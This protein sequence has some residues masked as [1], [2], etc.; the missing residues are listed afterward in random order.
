MN[1]IFWDKQPIGIN[2]YDCL[3]SEQIK[4][5]DINKTSRQP[6]NLPNSMS[7]FTIL[8][9]DLDNIV[10][11][12]G[13]NYN[14]SEDGNFRYYYDRKFLEWF[15]SQQNEEFM[16]LR[17]GIKLDD[18]IIGC[19]FGIPMHININNKIIKQI[20]INFLCID[21][22]LRGI[23]LAPILIDEIARRVKFHKIWSAIY[24]TS[25]KLPNDI[26]KVKYYHKNINILK[27]LK[28]GY[29]SLIY[30]NKYITNSNVKLECL[31]IKDYE[32]C[33]KKLNKQLL[34]Y[35][36][37]RCFT[38]DEFVNH[39]INNDIVSCY[40]VKS[41]TGEIT[42]FISWYKLDMKIL[43][44]SKEMIKL[45]FFY[46]YFNEKTPLIDLVNETLNEMKKI[47]I[48]VGN[49]LDIMDYKNV[50]EQLNFSIGTGYIYYYMYNWLTNSIEPNELAYFMV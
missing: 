18:K 47:D 2:N 29:T 21:R 13:N 20:E 36:I 40:V 46:Y 25:I 10:K 49:C 42:D 7:W 5:I 9:D 35:R 26:V 4:Y 31:E 22:K 11:F 12:L 14:E 32:I 37:N 45:G 28:N 38:L 34:K 43:N 41:D 44:N 17:V 19:I 48:D 15:L 39:F 8:D 33:C 6:T 16:D 27:L 50:F 1:H 23:H 3:I 30:E 24:S